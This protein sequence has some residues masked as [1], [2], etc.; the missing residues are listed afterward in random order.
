[1]SVVIIDHQDS[2]TCNIVE[3]LRKAGTNPVVI[4][5]GDIKQSDLNNFDRIILSPGPGVPGDYLKTKKLLITCQFHKKILGICLG[6]QIIAE[7]FGAKTINLNHV[8]HGQNKRIITVQNSKL[9]Q[10]IPTSFNV[11]LYHSWI[12]SR[13]NFPEDLSITAQTQQG[14]IMAIAHRK[15]PIFGVQFHPESYI[16]EYGLEI[17]KNFLDA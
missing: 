9:F 6:H 11:G 2:F 4:D 5:I 14:N 17:I 8:V 3:L 16:S 15:L 7:F 1:M 10:N 13:E 12:V